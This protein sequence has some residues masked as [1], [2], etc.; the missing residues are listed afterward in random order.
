MVKARLDEQHLVKVSDTT[1]LT[2]CAP[3]PEN[4]SVPYSVPLDSLSDE[5]SPPGDPRLDSAAVWRPCESAEGTDRAPA[6]IL[7]AG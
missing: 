4:C 3:A 7:A 6:A 2:S 5:V 1:L